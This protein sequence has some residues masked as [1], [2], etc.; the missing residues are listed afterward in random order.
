MTVYHRNFEMGQTPEMFLRKQRELQLGVQASISTLFFL[1][2][3]S[4]GK[5]VE[6]DAN[7]DT[8]LLSRFSLFCDV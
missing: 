8:R 5:V 6:I 7:D 1:M 3:C 4:V 2:L